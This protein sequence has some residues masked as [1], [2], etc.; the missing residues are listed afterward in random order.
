MSIA[1]GQTQPRR[2]A[3]AVTTVIT[4]EDI[5]DSGARNLIEILN[6]VP[7]F[8]ITRTGN[9]RDPILSVRGFT[10]A[11]NQSI[12]FLIDGVRQTELVFGDRRT[13]LGTVPLDMIDRVEVIRGP[14]SALYGA[15]AFSAVVNVITKKTG[16]T[17]QFTV[18]G[19]SYD[20]VN[21]RGLASGRLGGMNLVGSVEYRETDDY[22]PYIERDQQTRLDEL[23]GTTASLAPGRANTHRAELGAQ[24]NI[25][26]ADTWL[27][28]R[29]STWNNI[30]LGTGAG[31]AL[32]PTG[33][34]D[35]TTLAGVAQHT[36]QLSENWLLTG[37][38]DASLFR[39][40]FNN[41]HI[42][43]AGAFGIFPDGVI[44]DTEFEERFFRLQTVFNYTGLLDHA[45]S[46]G[47][48]GELG[49]ATLL[50]EDRNYT[51]TPDGRLVPRDST[52]EATGTALG[53]PFDGISRDV[54]Y[55][56]LQDEWLFLP[57]WTLTWGLRYDHFSDFGETLSPRAVLVWNARHDLTV[58]LLYG[59]GFRTP[60]LL[61]THAEQI[62]AISPNSDLQPEMIDNFELAFNYDPRLNLRTQ[63]SF[64]YHSTLDQIRQQ[65]TG[66]PTFTPENV[67]KQKGYGFEI[68]VNWDITSQTRFSGYY[69][70]QDN[71]DETTGKDAGFTPHHKLYGRLQHE[72]GSW[73]FSLQATAIGNRDRVAEDTRPDPDRYVIFDLF[74]RYQ[75]S[76]SLNVSF[77]IRNL[78]NSNARDAAA[79]TASPEDVPLPGR[80]FYLST[81]V[82]F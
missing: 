2:A 34:I 23:F 31:S 18:S 79:S 74:T 58:K 14:G 32:D 66:G 63:L 47:F 27:T 5:R 64:W 10:S 40:S 48:G 35:A 33:T 24:L 1:T 7:G 49:E 55:A 57:N 12:L 36:Q 50:S 45:L 29:A 76:Q 82:Q 56:Y 61:E 69:A 11:F 53:A 72:H 43:P 68:D 20:T 38:L 52:D 80:H 17:K 78:F 30:G 54:G 13:V 81:R 62:P 26:N 6:Q 9:F 59:R 51:I 46:F 44:L 67:G 3:P 71:T 28:L 4:A 25:S 39:F 16:T 21:V 15:D 37:T 65:N 75:L 77:D 60:S 42:F 22:A 73:L 41:M 70:F 8:N 19:G